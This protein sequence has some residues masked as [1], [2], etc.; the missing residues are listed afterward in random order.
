MP[1]QARPVDPAPV[2]ADAD[3][4]TAIALRT[5]ELAKAF[6][7]TQAL[8]SCSFELR[9]GE[10]HC[11][12]GENGSGKS[13]LV[14][15]LAGVHR[16]DAGTIEL[17]GDRAEPPL[18]AARRGGRHR[19]RLPGG[20]RRR[21]AL[22][23]R[24]RLDG[25]PTACSPA[26]SPPQ[27]SAGGRKQV[28]DALLGE[29]PP[30][31]T[32][33]ERLSLSERQACCLARAL[34][35]DPRILILDEATSALDVAT[36]DRLFA[37]LRERAEAGA[38]VIFISHRMDEIAEIGDRCTVM[39]SGETVATLERRSATAD[40]L[41]RLMTGADHLTGGGGRR[42]RIAPPRRSCSP[43]RGSSCARASS[44]ASPD[45]RVTVRTVPAARCAGRRGR[46]LRPAR[47]PRRV[48]LRVQV[49]PRELRHRDA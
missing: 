23:A 43:S 49:G 37:L 26:V 13:T 29:S 21:A 18:A 46:R 3:R 19:H 11:V 39:R 1:A 16:P 30:L 27:R 31:D 48:A 20:A 22:G 40:E 14:K 6:G 17:G 38:A 34:V 36:R 32:P 12:V 33:V 47:A 35:R 8:R 44:S 41:V 4:P 45:S 25:R 9:R 15:I 10:V 42:A 24:E 5:T 7:P 2:A 28:L